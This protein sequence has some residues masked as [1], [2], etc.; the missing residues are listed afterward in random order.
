MIKGAIGVVAVA[1][2][3]AACGLFGKSDRT[4]DRFVQPGQPKM[5]PSGSY[6]ALA[7]HGPEENGVATWVAVIQDK[8]GKEVFRDTETYSTRHGVGITWLS[9]ADQ[10]WLLS[11][12]VGTA[13]V[14]R[15]PD[16]TWTKTW[17]NPQ[18]VK[19]IP[20]EIKASG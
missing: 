9:N 17:M 5:S 7:D 12:D 4:N 11:S 2:L 15:N 19:D 18:T 16:G 1:A 8:F 14:D 6:T 3:V 20:A 13:H 10:L